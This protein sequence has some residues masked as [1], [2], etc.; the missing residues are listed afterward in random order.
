MEQKKDPENTKRHSLGIDFKLILTLLIIALFI[1]V[2]F[3]SNQEEQ[4]VIKSIK[5]PVRVI[6]PR[7]GP[8]N[9][10]FRLSGYLEAQSMVTIL[11]RISGVLL[12]LSVDMGDRIKAGDLLAEIDASTYQLQLE[13]AKAAFLAS[14]STFDRISQLYASNAAT[15]QTYEEVKA[16]YDA[17]KAQYD[18]A[19]LQYSYT[20]VVSPI[21]G[22]VLV[23]HTTPG[24]LVAPQVPLVTLGNT[25]T[26]VI[27][28]QVPERYYYVFLEKKDSMRVS[29]SIPA[30]ENREFEAKIERIAPYIAPETKN[31]EVQ[32]T[33]LGSTTLVRPGMFLFLTFVLEEREQTAYLPFS[34]LVTGNTLWYADPDNE[35]AHKLEF[36]PTYFNSTHF[37]IPEEY[38]DYLFIEEGQHFL[39]EAQE[40]RI[41]N[42]DQAER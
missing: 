40:I 13:Q 25:D 32:C 12:S 4:F 9:R 39:R 33:L 20:R 17:M 28:A 29:I 35:R 23:K 1:F 14:R 30:L 31:F 18:L 22:V 2:W 7:T 8:L 26:L 10:T 27:K 34:T 3:K 42:L 36:Q 41:I 16:H 11:P 38:K 24:A 21:D 6:S 19:E 5:T 37:Q 15:R